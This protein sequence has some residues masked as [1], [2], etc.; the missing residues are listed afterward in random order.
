MSTWVFLRGLTR[1]SR[2]WGLFIEQFRHAVL[3]AR[4]VTPELPG[5]GFLNTLRSPAHVA[6]M[7]EAIRAQ[8][9]EQ[10]QHPPYHVLAMSLGAMVAVA[11]ASTYPQEVC[12]SVLI[13]TSMR[14]FS[15]F[16]RRLRPGNYLRLLQRF[17]SNESIEERERTIL[18]LTS[19]Q[20]GQASGN[21]SQT[22]IRQWST[23]GKEHPVTPGNALR[24][25]L[26]A[27]RFKAPLAPPGSP[28]LILSGQQDALVDCTCSR[29]LAQVWKT[30]YA[31]HPTAG[32]D[33]PLD[34]GAWVAHQVNLWLQ[35]N[36][37]PDMQDTHVPADHDSMPGFSANHESAQ[38][39]IQRRD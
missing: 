7:V 27:A 17:L 21:F 20:A 16:Y 35:M 32:H 23:F 29:Q 25:L 22:L 18:E 28:V 37:R 4:I 3:D 11:W 26:A 6:E 24:Q 13:N 36:F 5:N 1:E 38:F 12:G 39:R 15:P 34:D 8:L 2:H 9:S 30:A 14:P 10:D 31:E 19:R 33:I